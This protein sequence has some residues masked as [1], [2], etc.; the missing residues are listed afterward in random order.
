MQQVKWR[1][2]DRQAFS[3]GHLTFDRQVDLIITGNVIGAVQRSSYIRPVIETECNNRQFPQGQLRDFDLG[4]WNDVRMPASV[5]TYVRQATETQLIILYA[6]FHWR[7]R[8]RIVHGWVVTSPGHH[9]LRSFVTGPT[10]KSDMVIQESLKYVSFS[11]EEMD[12]VIGPRWRRVPK[13][14]PAVASNE[15]TA[16]ARQRRTV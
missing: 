12:E 3:S 2:P 5:R 9:L 11:Q 15:G 6:F 7:G 1:T 16:T 4:G 13:A 8:A 10:Y 14:L